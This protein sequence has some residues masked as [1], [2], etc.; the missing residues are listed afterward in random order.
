MRPAARLQAVIEIL[1]AVEAGIASLGAPADNIVSDYCRQRRYIGSKDR[2]AITEQAYAVLR[3]RGQHLWRLT[4]TGLPPSGRALLMSHL[5]QDDRDSLALFGVE[6]PHAPGA[7]QPSEVQAVS[8]FPSIENNV[9]APVSARLE[10]PACVEAALRSRFGPAFE[11]AAK[12][13]NEPATLD[14]RSNPL[15]Q[16]KK[17]V[18]ALADLAEDMEQTPFSPIG[19][20]SAGRPRIAG[21]DLYNQGFVEVQDEAAQVASF[22][23]NVKPGMSVIDLCAGAGGKSLL[24]SALMQNKGQVFA[25]DVS[26]RRLNALKSRAQRAGCRNIQTALL[27]V[28]EEARARKLAGFKGSADRVIVDAPCSGTGTW[29]RNPDQKWRLSDAQ[30]QNYAETQSALL[31]EAASMVRVGG[32]I[33]Y[34]TCSLLPAENEGVV[35]AFLEA[36]HDQFVLCDYREDWRACLPGEPA[37]TLSFNKKMLQL[38]PHS[39]GTDGFFVATLERKAP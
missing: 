30:I 10:V 31:R 11:E 6:E 37:E 33:N 14:V 18:H 17:L 38:A 26:S 15:K 2:R 39:H 5:A 1:D 29:R 36:H 20:R 8:V 32:R 19:F 28:D 21:S 27:P 9:G 7:L 25:L 35:E 34:M 4:A 13:L 24:V 16:N 22:L 3:K 23:A 12:A